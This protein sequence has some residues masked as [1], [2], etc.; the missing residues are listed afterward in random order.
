MCGKVVTEATMG[1][2]IVD[3]FLNVEVE[4][5]G[6]GIPARVMGCPVIEMAVGHKVVVMMGRMRVR[7]ASI[8]YRW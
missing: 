2:S 5:G 1:L 4:R 6:K 7:I 3:L 8:L